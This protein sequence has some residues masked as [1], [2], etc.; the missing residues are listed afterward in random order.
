MG[1]GP[2]GFLANPQLSIDLVC[3]YQPLSEL[4]WPCYS[5]QYDEL[6][7]ISIGL[8]S[9]YFSL[10]LVVRGRWILIVTKLILS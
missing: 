7:R 9:Q 5:P 8:K 10:S 6:S 2:L 1:L 3:L 4:D